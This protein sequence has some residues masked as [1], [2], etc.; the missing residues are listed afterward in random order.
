MKRENDDAEFVQN[1]NNS[2]KKERG[3]QIKLNP[4]SE[5]KCLKSYLGLLIFFFVQYW[6]QMVYF[7]LGLGTDDFEHWKANKNLSFS[8]LASKISHRGKV[9]KVPSSGLKSGN[10]ATKI[11]GRRE[12]QPNQFSKPN[13]EEHLELMNQSKVWKPWPKILRVGSSPLEKLKP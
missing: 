3:F 12:S 2:F 7:G 4:D 10:F 11:L 13:I 6:F 9:G 5:G 1:L 8:Q